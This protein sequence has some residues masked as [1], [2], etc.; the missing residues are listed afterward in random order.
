MTKD[1]T[2]GFSI[3][4]SYTRSI[5]NVKDSAYSVVAPCC[6]NASPENIF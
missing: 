4:A 6:S 5:V 2:G 1:P 3:R